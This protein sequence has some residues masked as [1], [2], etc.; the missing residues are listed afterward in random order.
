[1][2]DTAKIKQFIVDEFMPDM[3]PDELDSDFD[4][5]TG[6]AVDS[7]GLLKLVAWMESEFGVSVDESELGPDSLRTVD[8]IKE[9]IDERREPANA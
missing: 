8:S 3:S 5:Q 6:G 4:L 1:V 7:L 2:D 9:F